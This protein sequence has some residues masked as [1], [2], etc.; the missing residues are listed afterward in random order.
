MHL[1]NSIYARGY[2]YIYC[3]SAL[4]LRRKYSIFFILFQ[5]F[6]FLLVVTLH[7]EVLFYV[8]HVTY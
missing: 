6:A 1:L 2:L 4:P 7:I 3:T 8:V 5:L